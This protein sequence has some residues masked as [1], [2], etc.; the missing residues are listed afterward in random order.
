MQNKMDR[1]IYIPY[2]VHLED[3]VCLVAQAGDCVNIS[4]PLKSDEYHHESFRCI[5]NHSSHLN[6]ARFNKQF[7]K[8]LS[9][10][11]GKPDVN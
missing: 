2:I 10:L 4:L 3:I 9:F 6:F 7:W 8:I 5:V 11:D 1:K